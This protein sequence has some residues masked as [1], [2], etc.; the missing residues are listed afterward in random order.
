LTF[1]VGE[2]TVSVDSSDVAGDGWL[3]FSVGGSRKVEMVLPAGVMQRFQIV[4]DYAQRTVTLAQPRTLKPQGTAVPFRTNEK[5]GLIAVDITINGK[6]YPVTIDSGSAYTWLRKN[7]A[8]EWLRSH[9]DWQRGVG[10]V[11]TSNMRMEDDGVEAA[12][13]VIRIPELKL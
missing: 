5:T 9:P 13:T 10:A 6:S 3:P 4:I 8:Q 1:R 12:G 11:G 2:M 7:I